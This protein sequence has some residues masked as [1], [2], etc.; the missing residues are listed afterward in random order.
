VN[1]TI[2]VRV[3]VYAIMGTKCRE[4]KLRTWIWLVFFGRTFVL[5]RGSLKIPERGFRSGL[6][7]GQAPPGGGT[8]GP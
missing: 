2:V 5:F 3:R 1:M 8:V 6:E 7:S 4:S